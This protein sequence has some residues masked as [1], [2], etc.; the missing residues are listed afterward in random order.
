MERCKAGTMTF[1]CSFALLL[2]RKAAEDNAHSAGANLEFAS[3]RLADGGY[4]IVAT[5]TG[6]GASS[7]RSSGRVDH[8]ITVNKL[9]HD[10]QRV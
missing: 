6:G 8:Y 1:L 10:L 2:M 7:A 4:D 5:A 9:R 3:K